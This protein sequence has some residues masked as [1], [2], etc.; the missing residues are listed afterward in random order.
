MKIPSDKYHNAGHRVYSMLLGEGLSSDKIGPT[1]DLHWK[2]MDI[3]M[4]AAATM[5]QLFF[6][7]CRRGI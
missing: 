2:I 7:V 4:S 3:W 1:F 5:R 6:E